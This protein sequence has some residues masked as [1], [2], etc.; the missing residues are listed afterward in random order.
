M[1][2]LDLSKGKSAERCDMGFCGICRERAH[3][4]GAARDAGE[5][6]GAARD[7]VRRAARRGEIHA[8]AHV[9]AS[10]QLRA[11]EGRF[12]RRMRAVPGDR[13]ASKHGRA[14]RAGAGRARRESGFG[15]RGAR[16]AFAANASRRLGH[17]ARS[18][19]AAESGG[20]AHPARRANCARCSA[21]RISSR[22]RNAASSSSTARRPCAG[23]TP[24]S[25]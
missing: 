18:G 2:P 21:P 22:W 11:A 23:T 1:P 3:R 7:A 20:A 8:G 25:S 6:A 24:T 19:A 4:G 17:R 14:R 16:A 5:R 13:A 12:L 9:R 10:G 15:H